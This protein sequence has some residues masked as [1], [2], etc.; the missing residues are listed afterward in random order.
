MTRR[1]WPAL[2]LAGACWA[3][4]AQQGFEQ[5][6][7]SEDRLWREIEAQLPAYPRQ[8]NLFQVQGPAAVPNR[9]F[10]DT[11]SL[12]VDP[13]GVVRYSLLVRTEGGAENVS[14]EGMRCATRER[15]LYAFGRPDGSWSRARNSRWEPVAPHVRQAQHHMILY[16]DFFCPDGQ[17]V[18]GKDEVMRGLRLGLNPRIEELQRSWGGGE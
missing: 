10:L 2:L 17:I 7:E 6:F 5:E 3:A 12:S 1:A 15:R 4:Q 18:R 16:H 11:A 13:D 14:F 8:E 9:Y